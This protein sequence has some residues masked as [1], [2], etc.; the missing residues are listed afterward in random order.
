MSSTHFGTNTILIDAAINNLTD[1]WREQAPVLQIRIGYANY[2]IAEELTTIE[3]EEQD[4]KRI[5]VS[6]A[7]IAALIA[8]IVGSSGFAAYKYLG[9]DRSMVGKEADRLG[10]DPTMH[11]SQNDN[12]NVMLTRPADW[13]Q[14]ASEKL[15]LRED[16]AGIDGST[17]TS[18][19]GL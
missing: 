6:T 1:E 3:R 17:A 18:A 14:I 15:L 2:L 5:S 19:L 13:R 16:F 7:V 9:T 10:A 11:S 12:V 8:V 4:M